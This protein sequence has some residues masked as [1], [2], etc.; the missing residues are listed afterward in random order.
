[1]KV[2]YFVFLVLQVFG[3][4]RARAA[5][6]TLPVRVISEA[7]AQRVLAAAEQAAEKLHA[8]CAIAVVDRSGTLVAFLKMDGVRDGS[9]DLAIGK[10]RTSALLQRPSAETESNVDSGR[11]A[12]VTAGFMTL[13]GGMPLM[14]QQEVVGAVGIAGLNKDNDVA[15]AQAAAGAFTS[16]SDA[17]PP[18]RQP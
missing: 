9:P 16:M 14:A 17:Q 3:V 2:A 12:F 15:I 4:F 5:D 18:P 13:R 1:M 11:T 8:P 7:G 10:A 6:S